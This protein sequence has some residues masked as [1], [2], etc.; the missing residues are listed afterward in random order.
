MIKVAFIF[1]SPYHKTGGDF[2]K[3]STVGKLKQILLKD[4]W[5]ENQLGKE[6][7][8][9]LRFFSMG[10][11]LYDHIKLCDLKLPVPH[12]PLPILVHAVEGIPP[13]TIDI[14]DDDFCSHC[15][16]F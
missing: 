10:K 4:D 11:E 8:S 1:S 15:L 6:R 9:Y 13:G 14:R 7:I 5:P 3:E 2:E 16:V 12:H